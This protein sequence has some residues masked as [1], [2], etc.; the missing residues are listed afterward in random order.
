M[1]I[2]VYGAYGYQGKLVVAELSRRGIEVIL[3]GRDAARLRSVGAPDADRRVADIGDHDSL[4]AAFRGADAVIN[5]AGPFIISG[6]PVIHAAVAAGC[7]YVDTSGEQVHLKQ[8]FETFSSDA[9]IGIVPGA[10]D[11]CLPS[12]L[13]AA[14]AAARVAP[15]KE[16]T[17]GLDLARGTAAPSR[18]TLRSALANLAAFTTGGDVYDRGQWRPDTSARRT[19]MTFPGSPDPVPVVKFALPGVVTVPRHVPA[20]RVEGVARAELVAAFSSI[21]ADLIDKLPEGPA[22]QHRRATR[23][24]VIVEAVGTDDRRRARGVIEGTDTY[25]TTAIIAVEAAR[26]LAADPP[27]SGALAPAQAFDPTDFLNFL[28]PHG[29]T[30]TIGQ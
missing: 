26:R 30:W 8:V 13:I 7:H 14:L 19:S 23:F 9:G 18:G 1:K 10:N 24:V 15:V 12:D 27:K 6:M 11:D 5:C 29:L 21:T 20:H 3:A 25:G 28:T 2:A 17:I 16:I 22:A 4:V